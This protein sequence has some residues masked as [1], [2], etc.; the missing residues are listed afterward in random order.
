MDGGSGTAGFGENDGCVG[1]GGKIF[2]PGRA[3][4]ALQLGENMVKYS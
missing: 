1:G 3:N 2:S 4:V